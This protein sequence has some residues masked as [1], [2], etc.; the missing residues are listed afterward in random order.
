[1]NTPHVQSADK[2]A[3]TIGVLAGL[4]GA[5]HG[6]GEALQGSVAPAGLVINSWAE[7]PIALYMGGEPA[8]TVVPNLLVTGV[9]TIIASLS[10]TAWSA[11]FT[12]RNHSGKIM[13]SLS[14][15]M[16]LVGGGFGPPAMGLMAGAA[17]TR[18]K[19]PLTWWRRRL[20]S[21]IRGFLAGQWPWVFTVS[22]LNAVFLTV[23]SNVFPYLGVDRAEL[24]T[25]SFFLTLVTIP[26]AIVTGFAYDVQS[27]L[28]LVPATEAR[29][30]SR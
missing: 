14:T 1:L 4:A 21:K 8:M 22:A 27:S 19:S 6:V 9:L 11:L 25:N 2:I 13:L 30:V 7:G 3:R 26:A 29:S 20:S 24:F 18:I 15:L 5:V 10:L 17:A 12:H 28:E 16:L 23:G